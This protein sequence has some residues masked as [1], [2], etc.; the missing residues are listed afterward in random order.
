MISP[1]TYSLRDLRQSLGAYQN[2][3]AITS[4]LQLAIDALNLEVVTLMRHGEAVISLHASPRSATVAAHQQHLQTS[5][6][7][8]T[9]LVGPCIV[10]PA[11]GLRSRRES[12]LRFERAAGS[13]FSVHDRAIA[14]VIAS[15]VVYTEAGIGLLMRDG[16]WARAERD[17]EESG[18]LRKM[19]RDRDAL[20]DQ[21]SAIQ[22]ALSQRA[23]L[24]HILDT[25]V[26]AAV[27]L[28]GDETVN[29]RLRDPG[30]PAL[31]LRV[32][33]CG[34]S[35]EVEPLMMRIRTDEGA[36]GRAFTEGRLVV[37]EDYQND[38]NRL[39]VL[40]GEGLEA[41]MSAPVE[42][43]GR[44]IG[45]LT[46]ATHRHGRTYSLTEQQML[47]TFA[48]HASVA[49]TN[50]RIADSMAHLAF[51]DALTGLP[52]RALF[53]DRLGQTLA[54][55]G[56]KIRMTAVLFADLDNFKAVNDSL[57][58]AGGDELL[59]VIARRLRESLR[60]SDSAARFGGDEFAILL[61]DIGTERRAISACERII[62]SLVAPVTIQGRTIDPRAS[63]GVALS[64]DTTRDADGL[65]RDA[66]VAMYAAKAAGKGTYKLYAPAMHAQAGIRLQFHADLMQALD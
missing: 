27:E 36:V 35:A 51:H 38:E 1:P 32:A 23:P 3:S 6:A 18:R 33:G 41:A 42:E 63:F 20:L 15:A 45:A 29:L 2:A 54:R 64:H 58:H 21:L 7:A 22:R 56:R 50:A 37:I 43:N 66:D 62:A 53:V 65:L 12:T 24:Q 47:I 48:V 8:S 4:V 46:V 26:A 17:D 25:I 31:L 55:G 59:V 5:D 44:V 11:G 49:L 14:E 40:A 13:P 61:E 52:N 16:G 30:D 28:I 9:P 34:Y 19:L 39:P 10:L 60:P 57:G